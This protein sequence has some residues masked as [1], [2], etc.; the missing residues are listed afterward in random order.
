MSKGKLMIF[1]GVLAIVGMIAIGPKALLYL[2]GSHK[3]VNTESQAF[4]ISGS[5]DLNQLA[6]QLVHEKIIDDVKSFISVYS[7]CW[8]NFFSINS[9][10]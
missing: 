6:D 5:M 4:Y 8:V 2:A 9:K 10:K 3:S 1:G 7:F